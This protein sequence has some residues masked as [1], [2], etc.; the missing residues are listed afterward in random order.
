MDE[1]VSAMETLEKVAVI[2]ILLVGVGAVL[3]FLPLPLPGGGKPEFR[4]FDFRVIGNRVSISVKNVGSGDAHHVRIEVYGNS[5]EG[6]LLLNAFDTSGPS[7]LEVGDTHVAVL[8]CAVEP[9]GYHE[10]KIVIS[11]D[12]GITDELIVGFGS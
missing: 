12:E 11:C 10:Y 1:S 4:A 6:W 5:S 9:S 8:D 2:A 3:V 7:G